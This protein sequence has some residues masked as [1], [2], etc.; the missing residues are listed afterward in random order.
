MLLVWGRADP[1]FGGG[2]DRWR[3]SFP[4]ARTV[5]FGD[6]GHYVAEEKGRALA[7]AV[8]GFLETL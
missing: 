3:E 1:A 7:A 6:C 2:L 8:E 5:S 4:R